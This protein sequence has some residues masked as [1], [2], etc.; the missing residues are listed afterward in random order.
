MTS[1]YNNESC[2]HLMNLWKKI[3]RS[4]LSFSR[5]GTGRRPEGLITKSLKLK[6]SSRSSLLKVFLL[7]NTAT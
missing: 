1:R 6:C 2:N 7:S 5:E 3:L 4:E